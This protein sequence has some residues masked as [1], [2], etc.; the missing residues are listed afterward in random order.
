MLLALSFAAKDVAAQTAFYVEYSG[1]MQLVRQVKDVVPCI[2]WKGKMLPVEGGKLVTLSPAS[3]YLPFCLDVSKTNEAFLTAP[4]GVLATNA[5]TVPG[6]AGRV[7]ARFAM[8]L[9]TFEAMVESPQAC[10]NAFLVLELHDS[11]GRLA[12]FCHEIGPL[13][14]RMPKRLNY[15]VGSMDLKALV[16]DN[17]RYTIHIFSEGAEAITSLEGEKNRDQALTRAIARRGAGTPQA[18]PV[19]WAGRSPLYPETLLP[20]KMAGEA[21]VLLRVTREGFVRDPVVETATNPA[22]GEAA[23][24]AVKDWRFLPKME[25]G[26]AVETMVR[27]PFK[28]SPPESVT[29]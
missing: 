4:E 20:S 22:F 9:Y 16:G 15:G 29:K 11:Q 10:A 17:A 21:T 1:A 18:N 27:F 26:A 24:A 23:L 14:P 6:V 5:M 3:D 7:P 25:K 2:E 19:H 12:L 28:F 8:R 13:S